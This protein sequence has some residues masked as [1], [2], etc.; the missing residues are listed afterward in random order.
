MDRLS[1]IQL[2][3][4]DLTL[5]LVFDEALR[6]R[7]FGHVAEHL[8]LTPSAISHA[9]TRLRSVFDDPLFLRVGN[10]VVPTA[11]ALALAGPVSR[12]LAELRQ[13]LD[14]GR[15]F[16]PRRVERS[17][18]IAAPDTVSATLLPH[19]LPTFALLAPHARFAIMSRGR[20]EAIAELGDGSLDL[21]IGVFPDALDGYRSAI[22]SHETFVVVCRR[23]HPL[24]AA[25]LTLESFLAW[26]HLLVS[27]AG[28]FEGAVDVK[29]RETGQRRRVV[30]A[31]PQFLPALVAVAQSDA[32]VTVSRSIALGYADLLGLQILEPPL[33]LPGFDVVL[34]TGPF[35]ASDPAIGWLTRSLLDMAPLAEAAAIGGARN[36]S[37]GPAERH[38][39]CCATQSQVA[40]TLSI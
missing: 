23:G 30:A 26:D 28:D 24:A 20:A 38:M 40:Q 11:R 15:S 21:A 29:L 22:L 4:L 25:P 6:T 12:I 1:D 3:R 35:G 2:R 13:V 5:L 37:S 31:L 27:A 39:P 10:S 34:L 9:M 17:F 7:R 16:D 32:I 36:H 18:R 33:E 8:G 14:E 19:A